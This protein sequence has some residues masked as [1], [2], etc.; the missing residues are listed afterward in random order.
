MNRPERRIANLVFRVYSGCA[1][2]EFIPLRNALRESVIVGRLIYRRS[3]YARSGFSS[4]TNDG[5][6]SVCCR[7]SIFQR[8]FS[9]RRFS[10]YVSSPEIGRC[11]SIPRSLRR[12]RFHGGGFASP[13]PLDAAF[14]SVSLRASSFRF[15]FS[16]RFASADQIPCCSSRDPQT[17]LRTG[18][19]ELVYPSGLISVYPLIMRDEYAAR[20]G[21]C[22][23][24]VVVSFRLLIS[25]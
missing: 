3:S 23:L 12:I 19:F 17:C 24:L 25:I 14:G 6:A 4:R 8:R 10:A 21:C 5:Q 11:Y 1:G 22:V 13:R 16:Y 18:R 2:R 9:G 15:R 20:V 7:R